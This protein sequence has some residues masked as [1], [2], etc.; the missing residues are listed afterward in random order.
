MDERLLQRVVLFTLEGFDSAEQR[1][2]CLEHFSSTVNPLEV[3][4]CVER[5]N[6]LATYEELWMLEWRES[7]ESMM[8][9]YFER[10]E[11]N[12]KTYVHKAVF[13]GIQQALGRRGGPV[14]DA[15]AQ[16]MRGRGK[17]VFQGP[18]GSEQG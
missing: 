1:R 5:V 10:F 7:L 3:S 16:A 17:E 11:A 9:G 14:K 12:E 6:M 4:T 18:F 13:A 15:W 2:L 8:T